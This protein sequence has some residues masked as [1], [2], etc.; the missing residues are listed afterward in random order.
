MRDCAHTRAPQHTLPCTAKETLMLTTVDTLVIL[1][2]FALCWI[3]AAI[4]LDRIITI[5]ARHAR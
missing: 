1:T 3:G 5:I 2:G 4:A